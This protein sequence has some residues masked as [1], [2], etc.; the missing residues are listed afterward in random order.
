MKKTTNNLFQTLDLHGKRHEEVY[1]DVLYFIA[2][3]IPPFRII[4]GHSR[5]MKSIVFSVLERC[6]CVFHYELN[7]QEGSIIVDKC[8]FDDKLFRKELK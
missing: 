5:K 3:E 6:E 7:K 8:K 4:T 1:S 2:T